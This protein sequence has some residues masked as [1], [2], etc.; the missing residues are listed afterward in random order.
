MLQN[1]S[2][3]N[4]ALIDNAS[5]D[6][7]KGLTIITGE[8]GAGKSI[9][10][11]ALSL[12]IGQR[13]DT[14][15]LQ[16]KSKKCVVEGTFNVSSYNLKSFFSDNEL[17]YSP[18]TIIRREINPAG[19]SRAFINDTP[20]NLN[21]LKE[22]G[23]YL[24]DVH[25]QHQT[26]AL[27]EVS[28]QLN[29]V[30]SCADLSSILEEYKQKFSAYSSQKKQLAEL[31]EQEASSKKEFD[32]L[33][34]QFNELSEANFK[35][36][37]QEELEQELDVLTNAEEIKLN[38]TR[39]I[40]GLTEGEVNVL[41]SLAEIKNAVLQVSKY[42]SEIEGLSERIN[43]SYIELKDIAGELERIEEEVT[44][45]PARIEQVNERLD[46]I[47]RFQ[48]KHQVND[49]K[50]LI[51]LKN[52]LESRIEKISTL[53]DSILAA[54]AELQKLLIALN[55]LAFQLEEE[56]KKTLPI[57]E[58]KIKELLSE[59]GMP[60]SEL[61]IELVKTEE[62]DRN[63]FNKCRFLFSA[64]KGA[65]MKDISK[66]ASGGE[67]SRLML[68][69]KAI[70]SEKKSLPTIIFD[71]IDTG[72][73]GDVAD[74]VGKIMHHMSDYMQVITITHL[75][76]IASKGTSHLFVYKYDEAERTI[77][78]IKK[79]QKEERVHEIAKMLSTGT[80]GTAA[81]KNAK[82]LLAMV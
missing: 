32:Y 35:E 16:D 67:L 2:I 28:Y 53:D 11:G 36:G 46:L 22:L 18:E 63:G 76:Q 80:P 45:D 33:Q 27:N 1:L 30:D 66:V 7:N 71:E 56:R 64:N 10:L 3:Q 74:K 47:Y 79:L 34:F 49:V 57:I 69:I 72:V 50:S 14:Q 54:D 41:T 12:I 39:G 26:L 70:V 21:Q 9:L 20:V 5:I 51:E 42:N 44:F 73:S 40:K 19:T 37:E 15:V 68:S 17:D 65:E 13:A 25:S 23:Q 62:L 6:I 52:N 55:G 24:V 48:K 38:L 82:E 58:S 77:T 43:S 75:P 8:T 4:Y 31:R 29:I 78:K 60:N 81:I 59:Q 61:R